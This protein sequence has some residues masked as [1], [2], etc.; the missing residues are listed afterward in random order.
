[1][2]FAGAFLDHQ[3][4]QARPRRSVKAAPVFRRP[5][6]FLPADAGQALAGAVPDHHLAA[7]V[8][9]EGG[10]RKHFQQLVGEGPVV[11]GGDLA[12]RALQGCGSW[13]VRS[14]RK[15]PVGKLL[16]SDKS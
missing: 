15:W 13:H 3:V 7:G 1:V 14:C 16:T 10:H 11:D 4:G 5:Q 12:Q 8:E 9:H 6:H 2:D